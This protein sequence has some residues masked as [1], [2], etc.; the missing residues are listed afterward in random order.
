MAHRLAPSAEADLDDIWLYAARDG[1]SMDVVCCVD[2]NEALILRLAHGKRDLEA[3]GVQ[4]NRVIGA[5][6]E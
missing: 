1:R 2:G 3:L 6:V 4:L 5:F